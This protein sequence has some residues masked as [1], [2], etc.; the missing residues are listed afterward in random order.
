MKQRSPIAVALLPFVTFG[1][2]SIY[3]MVK[4][5]IEM[6]E[7][8]QTIPTAWLIIIPFVNIW[9]YWKYSEAVGNVTNE[10]ISGVLAFV[11]LLLLG[12]IGQAIIQDSFNKNIVVVA[13]GSAPAYVP[14]QPVM[15]IAPIEPT[16][17]A[18]VVQPAVSTEFTNP[19]EPITPTGFTEPTEPTNNQY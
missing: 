5:K 16:V 8:G 13:S 10:K 19:T 6:N 12:S 18:E 15:P 14:E 3:W 4:T 11:L 17:T 7:K 2:Y 9:W 1:I